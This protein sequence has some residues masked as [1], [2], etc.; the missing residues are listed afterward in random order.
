MPGGARPFPFGELSH[1]SRHRARLGR[2]LA[3]RI[4]AAALA[5]AGRALADALGEPVRLRCVATDGA[6]GGVGSEDVPPVA[7]CLAHAVLGRASL[8]LQAPLAVDLVAR[9]LGVPEPAAPRRLS[10]SERGLL[11]YLMLRVAATAHGW[12]VEAIAQ[13]PTEEPEASAVAELE[14]T[15]DRG[16]RHHAR[17]VVDETALLCLPSAPARWDRASR[18]S[19]IVVDAPLVVGSA[20]LSAADARG[21]SRGDVVVLDPIPGGAELRVGG[22]GFRV[23]VGSGSSRIAKGYEPRGERMDDT[24]N[25]LLQ[26]LP[27]DLVAEIG[28]LRLTG[29]ELLDLEPGAVLPLGRPTS[30]PVDL[31]CAGRVVARGELVDVDGETGVRLT[32]IVV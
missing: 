12:K 10:P 7:V 1:V 9:L 17:L 5:E 30:G 25:D 14:V 32:E 27:V 15:L 2:A 23:A 24:K 19:A 4:H 3:Q 6:A 22:G 29:K 11:L 20:A 28:R 31:T 26:S 8:A 21:L 13:E 18:L 16:A